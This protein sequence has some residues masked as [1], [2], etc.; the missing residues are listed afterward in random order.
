MA[1]TIYG[2][3]NFGLSAE[4]G[5]Y[6]NKLDFDCQIQEKLFPS[7]V[8]VDAGG[9]LYNPQVTFS[10]AG[11]LRTDET[12]ETELGASLTIANALTWADYI[13]GYSTGGVTYILGVKPSLAADDFEMVDLNGR[14]APF[15]ALA[16]V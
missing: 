13:P 12:L 5:L 11:V 16:A 8:G 2:E 15:M 10:M 3:A 7:S 6:V 9:T 4:T 1:A 14:F